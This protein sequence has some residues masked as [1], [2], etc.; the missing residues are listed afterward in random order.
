MNTCQAL[1]IEINS[2]WRTLRGAPVRFSLFF[3][4]FSGL[5]SSSLYSFLSPVYFSLWSRAFPFIR[6]EHFS[7][8]LWLFNLFL[9]RRHTLLDPVKGTITD[10]GRVK[11]SSWFGGG[12]CPWLREQW[13]EPW[14]LSVVAIGKAKESVVKPLWLVW[15][16][17]R[18]V[19]GGEANQ[20]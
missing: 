17:S 6:G 11:L 3:S 7:F 12:E 13:G 18:A 14:R 15:V 4:F 9:S 20:R 2:T 16:G 5:S 1:R 10:V 19:G 8:F